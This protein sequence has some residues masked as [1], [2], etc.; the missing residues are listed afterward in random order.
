[1][2]FTLSIFFYALDVVSSTKNNHPSNEERQ[3][4]H[5]V[6]PYSERISRHYVC[7]FRTKPRWDLATSIP[8]KKL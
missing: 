7:W 8:K 3:A 2:L 5:P 6:R 1:M 4:L